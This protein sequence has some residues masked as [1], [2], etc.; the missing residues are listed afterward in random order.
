MQRLFLVVCF[1]LVPGLLVAQEP[2]TRGAADLGFVNVAGNT[3]VTSVSIGQRLIHTT[4]PWKVQ[5]AMAALYARTDGTVSAEQYRFSV[6]G[7]HALT[8]RIGVYALTGWDRNTF[9]GIRRRFEEGLGMAAQ[10]VA[11]GADELALEWGLG[12]TQQVNLTRESTSFLS[13]RAAGRYRRA[14]AEKA[15][16]EQKVE[17]LPNF[18]EGSDWR[19]LS[20]STLV[21]P[22]STAIALKVVYTIRYDNLPEPGFARSDRVLTTGVQLSW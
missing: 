12:A 21:A 14:L 22:L 5:Q 10:L 7:D 13:G 2:V 11:A 1:S 3:S 17:F 8:A 6:R 4:G 18:E 15:F 20:E 16:A 19:L 9:A